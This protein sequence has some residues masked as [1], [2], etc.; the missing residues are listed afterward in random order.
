MCVFILY[1]LYIIF[2]KAHSKLKKISKIQI[3]FQS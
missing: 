2:I 3:K 1:C